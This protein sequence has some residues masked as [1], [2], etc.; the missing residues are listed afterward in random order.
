MTAMRQGLKSWIG[1][2]NTALI[3]AMFFKFKYINNAL[4]TIARAISQMVNK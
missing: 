4:N 1:G 2:V 3:V